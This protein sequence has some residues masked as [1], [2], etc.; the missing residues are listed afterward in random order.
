MPH[1]NNIFEFKIVPSRLLIQILAQRDNSIA[2]IL[3]HAS[4]AIVLNTLS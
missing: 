4:H 3:K 1:R 2:T